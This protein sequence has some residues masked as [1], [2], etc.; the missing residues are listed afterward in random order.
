MRNKGEFAELLK[1]RIKLFSLKGISLY[2]DIWIEYSERYLK[3]YFNI[4]GSGWVKIYYGIEAKGMHGY[5]YLESAQMSF[6]KALD[7]LP[8]F[9]QGK[10]R[11][12]FEVIESINPRYEPIDWQV[13]YKSGYR[14][15]ADIPWRNIR[16]GYMPGIDLKMPGELGRFQHLSTLGITYQI[17]GDERY[18]REI[19]CEILDWIAMNPPGYGAGWYAPMN[20]AIRSAN[21]SVALEFIKDYLSSQIHQEHVIIFLRELLRNLKEHGEFVYSHLEKGVIHPNHYLSN[22]AGLILVS[23][24][25]EA[26]IDE[27][28]KWRELALEELKREAFIQVYEDG[29]DFEEATGYQRLALEMFFYP[30]LFEVKANEK[31]DGSNYLEICREFFGR[32]YT[33]KLRK[34]F[35]FLRLS[36]KPDGRIPLIGDYDSGRFLKFEL[37]DIKSP[38]VSY[39]LPL[40]ACFFKDSRFNVEFLQSHRLKRY[41]PIIPLFGAEAYDALVKAEPVKLNEIKSRRFPDAGMF[42]MRNIDDYVFISC[43]PI[44]TAG[45]GGHGHNDKLSFELCFGGRD[46]IVDPGVYT[47][48]SSMDWRRLFRST[49]VHNTLT[50]NF[51][52]QNRFSEK[53]PWWGMLEDTKCKCLEWKV[54]SSLDIF[55][56]EHYG[57]T[58]LNPPLIHRRRIEFH[59]DKRELRIYDSLLNQ[60]PEDGQYYVVLWN[61]TLHPECRIEAIDDRVVSV[62]N[63]DVRVTFTVNEG[64]WGIEEAYYA[65]EYG[66][67]MKTIALKTKGSNAQN[68]RFTIALEKD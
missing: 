59:K 18:A 68:R 61:F 5:K 46:I 55:E 35:N 24:A 57:Y 41:F 9:Q 67:K 28:E 37:P 54:S 4:L 6:D 48:T 62:T 49:F 58:R 3:H 20:V 47:Y 10:A 60:N 66:V 30:T 13:D 1:P 52:E 25:T 39:L 12:I 43:G 19:I 16:Y 53:S 21:W 45:L 50:V 32:N 36:S 23:I 38:D 26:L 29:V 63:R 11:E 2:R 7:E 44:G 64:S 40:A 56:G 34:M 51:E 8:R 22:L 31:F 17:T 33:D 14:W 65:P 27:A 42:V 15:S